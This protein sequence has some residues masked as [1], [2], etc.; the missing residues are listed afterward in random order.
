MAYLIGASFFGLFSVLI[1]LWLFRRWRL[2]NEGVVVR[3]RV[4]EKVLTFGK[5]TRSVAG[6]IKYDFLTPRGEYV[7]KSVVVG[8][9]VL[10][11]CEEGSEI[12]VVYLKDNP[13]I[14]ETRQMV[15]TARASLKLPPLS[16]ASNGCQ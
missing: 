1:T 6:I 7:E 12:D 4:V 10:I 11:E 13:D 15:D 5:A 2:A 16:A 8:E 14:S 3:G 9:A